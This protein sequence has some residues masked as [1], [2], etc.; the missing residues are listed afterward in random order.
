[1]IDSTAAGA[2]NLLQESAPRS[3]RVCY[4]PG[5][6]IAATRPRLEEPMKKPLR[7]AVTGAAGQIATAFSTG[8]APAICW[9]ATSR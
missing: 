9:A 2:Y 1:M 8:S 6:R 3:E 4:A 5:Y 7:V